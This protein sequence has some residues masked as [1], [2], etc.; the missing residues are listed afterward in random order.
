MKY[1]RF[2]GE[3]EDEIIQL[4]VDTFSFSEGADEGRLIGNLVSDFFQSY[5]SSDLKVFVAIEE[6]MI[7]GSIFFSRLTFPCDEADVFL[8]APVAVQTDFQGQGVGRAL[9]NFGHEVL[10]QE[11][12]QVVVTYGDIN[13]YSKVGYVPISEKL[14]QAPHKLSYPEGWLAQSL[15]GDI[16][17]PI[18]GLPYCLPAIG[19]PEYW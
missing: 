1:K 12:V 6:E 4:F 15:L 11:G 2:E 18:S 7:V 17:K 9:I 19:R 10:R 5:I 13:F 14:I 16:V 3:C 8:M